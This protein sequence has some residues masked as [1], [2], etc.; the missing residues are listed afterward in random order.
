MISFGPVVE[1]GAVSRRERDEI[2]FSKLS[3]LDV[4]EIFR[5]LPPG[6]AHAYLGPK[7]PLQGELRYRSAGL[8]HASG[9]PCG[10]R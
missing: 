6:S 9:L 2:C 3:Y 1:E 7:E 10:F 5:R 4:W 8:A